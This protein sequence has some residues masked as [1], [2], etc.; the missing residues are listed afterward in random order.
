MDAPTKSRVLI[1]HPA[2]APYRIDWFNHVAR[3][4]ELVVC[5]VHGNVPYQAY[6]QA[7]LQA[8]CRFEFEFLERGFTIGR[9]P[10]RFG[11][12]GMLR[13]HRPDVV[14]TSELGQATFVCLLS[15][16][17]M[18]IKRVVWTDDS[19][20]MMLRANWVRRLLW[21]VVAGRGTTILVLSEEAARTFKRTIGYAPDPVILPLLQ[22]ERELRH[23]ARRA[24]LGG[25]NRK[26]HARAG[27]ILFVG[28]LAREKRVDR[29]LDAVSRLGDRQQ[30][31]KLRIAGDGLERARL[32][33]MAGDYGL[34][35]AVDFLGHIEGDELLREY[36]EADI[37]VLCSER[38]PWGAVVD[39]ALVLG[40]PV[41]CSASCGSSVLIRG[42][43]NGYVVSGADV[44][45]TAT[46]ISR[47]LAIAE[48]LPRDSLGFSDS[49]RQERLEDSVRGFLSAIC[50]DRLQSASTP[51]S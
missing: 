9:R 25:L 8:L 33:A 19:P 7:R 36:W 20:E 16:W 34:L 23:A 2:L 39:E 47:A 6:D 17:F 11:F 49:L 4:C 40:L 29:L 45:E 24:V 22:N 13:R 12:L 1:I 15:C 51:N 41:V 32:E 28:R 18:G 35:E 42:G 38:E 27:T 44:E 3:L 30:G 50:S 37:L 5:L 43:L 14:V 21:R 10:I 46:A 31:I 48:E 26:R